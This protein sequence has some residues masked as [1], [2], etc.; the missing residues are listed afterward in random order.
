MAA[1]IFFLATI[2]GAIRNPAPSV[3]NP[4][5]GNEL[6]Q[7][8]LQA[9][10]NWQSNITTLVSLARNISRLD[11]TEANLSMAVE[12]VKSSLAYHDS[13][14]SARG[15][16]LLA[17]SL[18]DF[19]SLVASRQK[20]IDII[21]AAVSDRSPAWDTDIYTLERLRDAER[22]GANWDKLHP[23]L[24]FRQY[25]N[26]TVAASAVVALTTGENL[27]TFGWL[28]GALN[29]TLVFFDAYWVSQNENDLSVAI[30][31]YEHLRGALS[32][33]ARLIENQPRLAP[34]F[35]REPGQQAVE[36]SVPAETTVEAK[37]NIEVE[38][39]YYRWLQGAAI[40]R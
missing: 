36:K 38:P 22:I 37:K 2:V 39:E 40:W 28:A 7:T 31:S 15:A 9:P 14:T 33:V 8:I 35:V 4:W 26:V 29:H 23:V 18:Y 6:R 3:P 30:A 21:K 32:E 11:S 13:N 19:E 10:K 20:L 34:M 5:L 12:S 1:L 27:S 16:L 24:S 25:D 17:N